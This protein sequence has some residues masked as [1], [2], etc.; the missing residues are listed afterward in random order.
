MI[1]KRNQHIYKILTKFANDY[2]KKYPQIDLKQLQ[3]LN[4]FIG[5]IADEYAKTPK[6]KTVYDKCIICNKI[7]CVCK[8][9]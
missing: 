2:A 4:N 9:K 8:K 6:Q 7:N 3:L 1:N 5:F